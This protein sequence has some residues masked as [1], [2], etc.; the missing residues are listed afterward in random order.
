MFFVET[1]GRTIPDEFH[2]A[3]TY[4]DELCRLRAQTVAA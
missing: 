3:L 1:V 4:A 2:E